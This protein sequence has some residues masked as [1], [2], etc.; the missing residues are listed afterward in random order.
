MILNNRFNY[1]LINIR[2]KE[3]EKWLQIIVGH[4]LL[5]SNSKVLKRFIQEESFV[6]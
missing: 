2:L 6:G 1:D 3:L 5:R 4:P